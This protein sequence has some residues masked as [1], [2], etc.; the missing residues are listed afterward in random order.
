MTIE[1]LG[2]ANLDL[3]IDR[4]QAV[5]LPD[6]SLIQVWEFDIDL[7]LASANAQIPARLLAEA[8][9]DEKGIA[10]SVDEVSPILD[11]DVLAVLRAW[12]QD[13][14]RKLVDL[15]GASFDQSG[16]QETSR[17]WPRA[18]ERI[19][20]SENGIYARIEFGVEYANPVDEG[21]VELSATN[22]SEITIDIEITKPKFQALKCSSVSEA[23]GVFSD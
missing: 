7:P 1:A 9:L 11:D 5:T 6:D 20:L 16:E 21:D 18:V 19:A 13:N 23:P 15:V 8:K 2:E 12:S 10:V 3:M 4:A 14:P 17:A 22:S